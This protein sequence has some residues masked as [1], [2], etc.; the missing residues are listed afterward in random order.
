MIH[1]FLFSYT[2]YPKN[3]NYKSDA[4]DI[5]RKIANINEHL[6]VKN[7]EVDTV[8][9]GKIEL[10]GLTETKRVQ[11]EDKVRK[12]IR[13]IL[14]ENKCITKVDVPVALMVDGLGRT[15]EFSV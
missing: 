14:V 12:V 2:V 10:T 4:D 11:A 1:Y 9:S 8:F 7:R 15:M 5:R 13:D 3:Q 6:W